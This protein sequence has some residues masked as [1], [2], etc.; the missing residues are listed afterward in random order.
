MLEEVLSAPKTR[1]S[2]VVTAEPELIKELPEIDSKISF[3]SFVNYLKEN[4]SAVTDTKERFYNDLIEKFEAVPSLLGNEENLVPSG[5]NDALLE[6]LSSS[7]FPAL[8]NHDK[9]SF[10]LAAPYQFRVFYYSDSFGKL[11]FDDSKEHL[12]LPAGMPSEELKSIECAMIYEHVLEKFYGIKL[13]DSPE[14]IYPVTDA[15]TGMKRY[16]RIRYDRRFIDIDLKDKLPPIQDCAVC[17]NTFRIMDLEKQLAKMPLDL[18]EV[19]G[20][21]VWVAEDVTITESL[22]AIKKILLRQDECD[23]GIIKD[24]KAAI[25]TVVGFSKVEVGL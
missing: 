24:L 4:R 17:L 11:F 18:F 5:A 13:N 8:T 19:K 2:K 10:A 16:Y 22:D 15:Q 3:R 7:L 20:F 14:L 12:L 9:I 6:M 1:A 23:T 25:H 21:A